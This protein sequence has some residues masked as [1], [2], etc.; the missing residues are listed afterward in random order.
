MVPVAVNQVMGK[1][2]A[3]N[4]Q[5]RF[6]KMK[7]VMLSKSFAAPLSATTV[8]E[9]PCYHIRDGYACIFHVRALQKIP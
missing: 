2:R 9:M 6:W 1:G 4:L 8:R 5:V 7:I 3:Q